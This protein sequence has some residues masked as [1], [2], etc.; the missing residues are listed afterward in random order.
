L[1]ARFQL[2]AGT[3]TTRELVQELLGVTVGGL[4]VTLVSDLLKDADLVKF[5]KASIASERAHAMAVRVRT[6]IEAT[7]VRSAPQEVRA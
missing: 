7:A 5:A 4:D 6:L 2:P 1:Q 3:R